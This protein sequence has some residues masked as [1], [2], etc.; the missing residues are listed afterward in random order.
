MRPAYLRAAWVVASVVV[1]AFVGYCAWSARVGIDVQRDVTNVTLF[2]VAAYLLAATSC[3][4]TAVSLHGRRRRA[5]MTLCAANAL[6]FLHIPVLMAGPPARLVPLITLSAFALVNAA[7]ILGLMFLLP[8]RLALQRP[9]SLVVDALIIAGSAFAVVWAVVGRDV[10]GSASS[11]WDRR[12]LDLSYPFLSIAVLSLI[13]L[14]MARTPRDVRAS[15]R[16]LAAGWLVLAVSMPV[17]SYLALR[18]DLRL[19]Y[20]GPGGAVIF[21]MLVVVAAARAVGEAE[22]RVAI[23]Y[24]PSLLVSFAPLIPFAVALPVVVL[25]VIMQRAFDATLL[26]ATA[27]V[28]GLVVARLVLFL[29][30]AR[31]VHRQLEESMRFKGEMLRFISH[32]IGNPLLPLSVEAH[33]IEEAGL[34]PQD[35]RAQRNVATFLRSVKRLESLSRDVRDLARVDAGQL[36]MQPREQ[37]V[38]PLTEAAV[39]SVGRVAA[40]KG[41]AIRQTAP[42]NAVVAAVDSERFGQVVDNL[43]SNAVKFTPNGGTVDVLLDAGPDEVVVCV[44]DT[45]PGLSSAQKDQLFTAFS[46]PH[47][48]SA[49]GLGL[50]LVICRAIVSG[51]G[52]RIWAESEGPGKGS[53]FIATFPTHTEP[54]SSPRGLS[55]ETHRPAGRPTARGTT[56]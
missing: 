28:V 22:Q 55:S 1:A 39:Q 51:H 52:G 17:Y 26:V 24:K 43:L 38:K 36:K 5:W 13:L 29:V 47:G 14:V 44:Q 23:Q 30:D 53:R 34:D 46:R 49:P 21:L 56:G 15:L 6:A 2:Q 33:L 4:V 35:P 45:G 42:E 16:Y 25:A 40:A 12:I 37:D 50:G 20:V 54:S 41:I 11:S 31:R 7:G 18:G 8:G 32:E 27:L 3:G 48:T 10:Y 19:L 9:A